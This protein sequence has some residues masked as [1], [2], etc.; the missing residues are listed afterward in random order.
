MFAIKIMFYIIILIIVSSF[1]FIKVKKITHSNT[2]RKIRLKFLLYP[3]TGL[4]LLST[5]GSLIILYKEESFLI[6]KCLWILSFII[7]SLIFIYIIDIFKND[8]T[9]GLS[10]FITNVCLQ[11]FIFSFLYL[12]LITW[13][14]YF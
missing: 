9:E 13:I 6:Y 7:P 4:F 1:I 3:P 2:K 14:N 5:F 10:L 8:L 11:F 12:S